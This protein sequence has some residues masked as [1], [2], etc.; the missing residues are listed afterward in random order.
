MGPEAEKIGVGE[1]DLSP[2]GVLWNDA[3][4]RGMVKRAQDWTG[5]SHDQVHVTLSSWDNILDSVM[6]FLVGVGFEK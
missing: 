2:A 3:G 5:H 1:M 6:V 4:V